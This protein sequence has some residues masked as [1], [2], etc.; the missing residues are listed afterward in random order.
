MSGVNKVIL[1]GNLGKD[2]EVRYLE[3]GSVVCN[4]TMVTSEK[5]KDK[6]G[7]EKQLAEWHDI[8][9][10]EGLAKTAEKYLKKGHKV[11]IEGKIKTELWQDSEGKNRKNK[12]IKATA[13][14][15][16]PQGVKTSTTPQEVK[17]G[18]APNPT[19]SDDLPF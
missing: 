17:Q 7:Q 10:W 4:F 6:A 12:R 19:E 15:M 5:W 16:L 14:T 2:P 8:E 9:M 13:M 11:Y 1:L 18:G 3:N